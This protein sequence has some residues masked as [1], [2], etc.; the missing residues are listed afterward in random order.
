MMTVRRIDSSAGKRSAALVSR[1]EAMAIRGLWNG[2]KVP[3]GQ[4]LRIHVA[5]DC[6]TIEGAQYLAEASADYLDRGGLAVWTYTH[7]WRHVP[8][9][10]WGRVSVLASCDKPDDVAKAREQGYAPTRIVDKHPA[11]GKAFRDGDT[12]WIPCP[13]Q[14][15]GISCRDC[16]LCMDADALF[17][18]NA[19]VQFEAHGSGRKRMLRVLQTPHHGG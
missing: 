13:E 3:A 2:G 17:R 18:R 1:S 15:R 11:D 4:L 12:T 14:T 7:A 5:G 19:G 8:R 9:H 6:S 16:G 10:S